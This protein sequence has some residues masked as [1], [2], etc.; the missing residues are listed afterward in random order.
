MLERDAVPASDIKINELLRK[1]IQPDAENILLTGGIGFLGIFLL[2]SLLKQTKAKIYCLIRPKKVLNI[3][4]RLHQNL[5][6]YKFDKYIRSNRIVP[7]EGDLEQPRLGLSDA[8]YDVLADRIDN[9][10]HNGA[11]V[12][13]VYSY[14]LLKNTNVTA[15]EEIL[16]LAVTRRLKRV[17]YIS[18]LFVFSTTDYQG[19][20]VIY[21][22]YKP[23][24]GV[25]VNMGY[26]QSKW[27]AEKMVHCASERGI[28]VTIHRVGRICGDTRH[29]I[30]QTKDLLWTIVKTCIQ[31]Q[32]RPELDQMINISPVDYVSSAIV[33]I[34]SQRK[35]EGKTYH[36]L[37]PKPIPMEDLYKMIERLGYSVKKLT[38]EEWKKKA[39]SYG[40]Q[41]GD[42]SLAVLVHTLNRLRLE[43]RNRTFDMTNTMERL[44]GSSVCCPKISKGLLKK[45]FKYLT[46][47]GF[48]SK[49]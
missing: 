38:F 32:S 36:I 1:D 33:E 20:S 40:E 14:N 34:S 6:K 19:E 24:N 42:S 49:K 35:S 4:E 29:G 15:T 31:L 27:V 8:M 48:L 25:D 45:Y 26:G 30:C 12:N 11:V 43:G 39:L 37:N 2:N 17:H 41:Y 7:V 5:V 23:I 46:K 22:N 18:T 21:E 44:K 10:Y 28:P 3:E 47:I 16:R 9:I 13:Y